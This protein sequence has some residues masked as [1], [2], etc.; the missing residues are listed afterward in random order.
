MILHSD[1]VTFN[2][3][4]S[5]RHA[6]ANEL[7]I[8]VSTPDKIDFENDF[9]VLLAVSTVSLPLEYGSQRIFKTL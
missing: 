4:M 6:I 3:P 9:L 5:Y 8:I 1:I 7:I 2:F